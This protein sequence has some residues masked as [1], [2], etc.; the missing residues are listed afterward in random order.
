MSL[1][2]SFERET[3][4]REDVEGCVVRWKFWV[5]LRRDFWSAAGSESVR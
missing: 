4:G 5:F 1:E 2:I 3:N